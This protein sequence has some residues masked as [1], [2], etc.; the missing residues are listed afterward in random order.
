VNPDAPTQTIKNSSYAHA[1]YY[2]LTLVTP[3]ALSLFS[4][5]QTSQPQPRRVTTTLKPTT[6]P[7]R[8]RAY[9]HASS[10]PRQQAAGATKDGQSE[11]M[12]FRVTQRSLTPIG[13][14][15]V[16]QVHGTSGRGRIWLWYTPKDKLDA[17]SRCAAETLNQTVCAGTSSASD[18]QETDTMGIVS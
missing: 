6:V 4:P 15:R 5:V 7:D 17:E 11:R 3:P 2:S 10:A 8:P 1:N 9:V 18:V 14:R 13:I 12:A 16:A